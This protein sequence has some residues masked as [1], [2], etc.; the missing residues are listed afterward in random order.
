MKT[1][2]KLNI[3]AF[4][5]NAQTDYL[6]YYKNFSL[7]IEETSA[8]LEV[9]TMIKEQN[10]DFSFPDTDVFLR[11]NSFITSA[12][13]TVEEL[14]TTL[15][16]ELQLDPISSYRSINGL[17]INDDDFMK[18]YE[19]LSNHTKDEDLS[20]YQSL[21]DVHY[22]SESSNY[23]REYIGDAVLLLASRILARTTEQDEQE[24]IMR[25]INDEYTGIRFCEYENNVLNGKSHQESIYQL[26]QK[27]LTFQLQKKVSLI[28]RLCSLPFRKRDHSLE[29]LDE[30][31]VAIYI[32]NREETGIVEK[33]KTELEAK[34]AE[35]IPF[36]RSTRKAG[37]SLIQLN[38]EL[39][40]HKAGIMMLDALD[41]GADTLVVVKNADYNMLVNA[42]ARAEKEVGR[43]IELKIL[44]L[45]DFEALTSKTAEA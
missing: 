11:V 2:L 37:Q 27:I 26:K 43:P 25:T 36:D 29:S 32:G 45:H 4:F 8:L 24:A 14:V 38:L 5:F 7:K 20:Y 18:N 35:H 33:L 6:P 34:G 22:A 9:L 1:M 23:N 28:E 12:D 41:N 21:Y 3:R 19:L 40:H 42:I 15:G 13:V 16:T 17:I 10:P 30:R 31:K 39:A 44:A